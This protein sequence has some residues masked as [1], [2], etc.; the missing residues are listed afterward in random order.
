M[1]EDASFLA[2]TDLFSVEVQRLRIPE[3]TWPIV[4]R[5]G[6]SKVGRTE[7]RH[8]YSFGRRIPVARGSI[9]RG[10][11]LHQVGSGDHAQIVLANNPLGDERSL[12]AVCTGDPLRLAE[13]VIHE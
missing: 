13:F 6:R 8:R 11:L 4:E 1:R 7:A 10:D 3:A 9:P 5:R 12:R 2:R